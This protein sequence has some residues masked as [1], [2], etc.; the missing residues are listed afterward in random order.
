MVFKHHGRAFQPIAVHNGIDLIAMK[1]SRTGQHGR[2]AGRRLTGVTEFLRAIDYV[3]LHRI[4]IRQHARDILVT[5]PQLFDGM[6]NGDQ[7]HFA[8]EQLH[9]LHTLLA[10]LH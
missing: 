5:R 10:P 8:V 7:R 2:Q 1:R 4:Q 9:F 6:A 3:L